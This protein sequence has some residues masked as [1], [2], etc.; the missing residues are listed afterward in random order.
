MVILS[1]PKLAQIKMKSRSFKGQK[2][3]VA[4]DLIRAEAIS[5]K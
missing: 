3:K 2:I 1:R 5:L 4:S